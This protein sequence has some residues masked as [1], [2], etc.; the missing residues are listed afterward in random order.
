M[1]S[2]YPHDIVD[3]LTKVPGP[4]QK[5]FIQVP[6]SAVEKLKAMAPEER[7]AWIK[8]NPVAIE[9]I[10]KAE[11]KRARKQQQKEELYA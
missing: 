6:E 3:D 11:A 8:A 9:I 2:R 5:F 4:L 7:A 1:D 10:S